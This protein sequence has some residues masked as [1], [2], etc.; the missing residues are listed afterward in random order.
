MLGVLGVLGTQPCGAKG[1]DC[2]G[3]SASQRGWDVSGGVVWPST[4][5]PT[6]AG[7]R[8]TNLVRKTGSLLDHDRIRHRR[9]QELMFRDGDGD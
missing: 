5:S 3:Y 2:V 9:L 7:V 4:I 1:I 8:R 6:S